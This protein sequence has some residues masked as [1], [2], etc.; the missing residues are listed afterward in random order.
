MKT[1]E[2]I[3]PKER[4]DN[5][6]QTVGYSEQGIVGQFWGNFS[7]TPETLHIKN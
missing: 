5:M 2:V 6:S 1:D 4:Y 3:N 7:V